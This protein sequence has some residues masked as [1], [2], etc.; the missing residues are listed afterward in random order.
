MVSEKGSNSSTEELRIALAMRG[1]VSLAVWIGGAVAELDRLRRSSLDATQPHHHSYYGPLLGLA[2]YNTVL[3]DVLTGA[4]AGGLNGVLYAQALLSG[5]TVDGMRDVWMSAADIRALLGG[6]WRDRHSV[7]DGDFFL[8]RLNDQVQALA[9]PGKAPQD[10]GLNLF[11]S[12]TVLGG[13]SVAIDDDVFSV[14]SARRSE[15]YFHFRHLADHADFSDFR[16]EGVTARLAWA[17]RTTAS[18]P[19]A[20]EPIRH[21]SGS[22]H[23]GTLRLPGETNAPADLID[24]GVVDNIPVTRAIA[25]IAAAPASRASRRWLLYLNPKPGLTDD[26]LPQADEGAPRLID[27]ALK[28]S[29]SFKS[30]SV[31]DDL[32][33]L[34][35]HNRRADAMAAARDASILTVDGAIL[36]PS[37]P[38]SAS[39]ALWLMNLLERPDEVIDWVP[40]GRAPARS[41]LAKANH[42]DRWRVRRSLINQLD[43]RYR[44]VKPGARPSL[45]RGSLR[46]MAPISR[47]ATL[48]IDWAR[49]VEE[50]RASLADPTLPGRIKRQAYE[51]LFLAR[52]V[53]SRVDHATIAFASSEP[54][55][56]NRVYAVLAYRAEQLASVVS[57]GAV[58]ATVERILKADSPPLFYEMNDPILSRSAATLRWLAECSDCVNPVSSPNAGRVDLVD[59]LWQGCVELAWSLRETTAEQAPRWLQRL[60]ASKDRAELEALLDDLDRATIGVHHG[61]M[62]NGQV[63]PIDYLRLAGTNPTPLGLSAEILP[64]DGPRFRADGPFAVSG[65]VPT[66]MDDGQKLAGDDIRNFAAF[67]SPRWRANDWM[68][69]QLDAAKSVLDLLLEPK[70]VH[71]LHLRGGTTKKQAVER[72]L[73]QLEKVVTAPYPESSDQSLDLGTEAGLLAQRRGELEDAVGSLWESNEAAV[74]AELVVMFDGES[75]A[76][77]LEHTK[78]VV[79]AR[80]HLDLLA[81][82]LPRLHH[83]PLEPGGNNGTNNAS[84]AKLAAES[85][86][87]AA[88]V[89]D[90]EPQGRS[91]RDVWGRTWLTAVGNRA[92]VQLIRCLTPE[93]KLKSLL[94]L[95][96]K[97]ITLVLTSL[98]LS[99]WRAALAV[100]I[101]FNF[102]MLPRLDKAGSVVAW[103]IFAAVVALLL[104]WMR[105][106]PRDELGRPTGE[107]RPLAETVCVV[108]SAV[109]F[110]FGFF[111]V[112]QRLAADTDWLYRPDGGSAPLK[113]SYLVL[114]AAGGFAGTFVLWSWSKRSVQ[115]GFAAG[116]AA[117]MVL[118]A[119]LATR[120]PTPWRLGFVSSMW[121]GFALALLTGTAIATRFN[122]ARL[123][124]RS[125]D[126]T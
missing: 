119:W 67:L 38:D 45:S 69:G 33:V 43:Q 24:G 34:R 121:W 46:P 99:R 41:P 21:R 5:S 68:W 87:L 97:A 96:V 58:I 62:S 6:N 23:E 113:T 44:S 109:S 125:G 27:V 55:D 17:A 63:A 116:S 37:G 4:S 2:N 76:Y 110:A 14:D 13:Q 102:V 79:L 106:R 70:R 84:P 103:L 28:L 75:D 32:E 117:V 20:F 65:D 111:L 25:A 115:I 12:G 19:A 93:S 56:A 18:F 71:R 52:L 11:L 82:E 1:G 49:T 61:A 107:V 90:Y 66:A 9:V 100:A 86:S 8:D 36:Q 16:Q 105:S 50:R 57:D 104:R 88:L 22:G 64:F 95:P 48:L 54:F 10:S 53:T 89:A 126:G 7:L 83:T 60:E 92:V 114:V 81:I 42:L 91:I 112:V 85:R 51:M 35:S 73:G 124:T 72:V 30:E 78:R 26:A 47:T 15:A 59:V 101:G 3:I 39:D 29:K 120:D 98:V 118:W 108:G 94:A 77:S 40:I 31:L 74:R 123:G 80:R 122:V